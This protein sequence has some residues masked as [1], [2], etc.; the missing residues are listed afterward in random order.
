M[1]ATS[2]ATAI[3]RSLEIGRSEYGAGESWNI[4]HKGL[5]ADKERKRPVDDFS[6]VRFGILVPPA[7]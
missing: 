7:L 5:L 6:L 1:A 4:P 2:T 3:S